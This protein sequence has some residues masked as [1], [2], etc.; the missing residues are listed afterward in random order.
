MPVTRGSSLP[1]RRGEADA[2]NYKQRVKKQIQEH[3]KDKIGG[4]DIITG[5]GK[6]RVPIKGNKRYRFI[7]D[8]GKKGDGEGN[9]PGRGRAGN[10]PGEEEYEVWLDMEEVEQMLFGEL[11]LPRLKPKQEAD[12]HSSEY[13][14]DTYALKGPQIDKKATLKRILER[15]AIQG[16]P[17]VHDIEKDDLRY[18]SYR[19]KPMPKSKAVVFLMMDV[20]GSMGD[21]HKQIARL[22]FYWTVRFLRFRYDTVEVRFISHTTEAKEVS[23]HEFFGRVE[24]GGTMVSSA[25][26]LAKELQHRHFPVDDWNIY[27]LHASDGDNWALDNEDTF[28][29]IKDL[30]KVCSLVG[31]LEI[32]QSHSNLMWA[33]SQ[34]KLFE[35]LGER[36][37]ELGEVFMVRRVSDAKQ[38]WP[39]LRHFF[40]KERIEDSV[41]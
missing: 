34:S 15:N 26:K 1:S 41:R 4:E 23:E 20:S 22:F 2:Q 21:F 8:R 18:I 6:L 5:E 30:C 24:S 29:A 17:G 27:V 37:K 36:A 13:K 40:A 33:N 11:D 16:K 12:I 39:A 9:G 32:K 10:E 35:V 7:L 28:Q 25:Y 31:Y 19:E 3:L 38:I 14:F